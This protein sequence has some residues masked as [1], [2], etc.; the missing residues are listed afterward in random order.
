MTLEPPGAPRASVAFGVVGAPGAGGSISGASDGAPR[1]LQ[2]AR[3]AKARREAARTVA[4]SPTGAQ[5]LFNERNGCSMAWQR[6]RN[7]ARYRAAHRGP[8]HCRLK[9]TAARAKTSAEVVALR[10]ALLPIYSHPPG[11]SLAGS[12]A[13][14]SKSKSAVREAP[15]L[16]LV[17]IPERLVGRQPYERAPASPSLVPIRRPNRALI[18][19][20]PVPYTERRRHVVASP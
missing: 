12:R 19:C 7:G 17:G 5:R 4:G 14:R 8:C 1:G 3:S 20:L 15:G 10:A 11:T 2:T 18:G 13:P 9:R 16:T 6:E